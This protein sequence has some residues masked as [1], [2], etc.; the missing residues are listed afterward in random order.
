MLQTCRR[1]FSVA[2][3]FSALWSFALVANG[4][5]AP[6]LGH[7]G[8]IHALWP[9]P[10]LPIAISGLLL[11][12][13]LALLAVRLQH[14]PQ[15]LL[16]LSSGFMLIICM[17]VATLSQWVPPPLAPRISW[18]CFII[19]AYPA[20]VP[21]SP[22]R[23]LALS[24]VAASMD[25]LALF[26]TSLRGVAF[27]HSAF[28]YIFDFVPTY[29][30]A[31]VAVVPAKII[32]ALSH[33]VR[34][35][36]EFGSYRLEEVLGKGGMGE[37]YRGT[38]QMLA[39]PAAVKIIRAEVLGNSSTDG[40][41]VIV[42]R[43]RR[44]AEAAASLRSPHTISL[45]DFGAADDGTFF[46]VMELLD[47]LD[48]QSLV[49]R[50]GPLPPERVAYLLRQVC[51][52]LEEAHV[53]GL[54]HRDI[55]PSNIFTCRLGLQTDFVKVLDFGLVK[56]RGELERRDTMLTA[57]DA[58][59]GTPAY[60]A[61][62]MV[63]GGVPIDHRVDIYALGCVAYWL[64]TGQLVFE[65]PNAIQLMIAH[66]QTPPIPPSQR[67]ELDIPPDFEA[68]V[69]ACLAK[70]PE[71]RPATAAELG[72]RLAVAVPAP[73]WGEESAQRWWNRH[74]PESAR[75]AP[76]RCDVLLSRTLAEGWSGEPQSSETTL[77]G[78]A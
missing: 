60:I 40:A 19:L 63:R 1:V 3:V 76:T 18:L 13:L 11:S 66:F 52:S 7:V 23:T 72:R 59:A 56:G 39:R 78:K 75:A 36:R 31:L 41:R 8:I 46:L 29:M 49:E 27:E 47:G 51:E 58:T 42:E 45:Y 6:L 74:H 4:I 50:F 32:R 48:L 57:P 77:A 5:L 17:M 70:R 35:A 53:R 67:V 69:M 21:A 61:P 43:F 55:K 64:L 54:I 38:H 25:P 68:V 10:G 37:V 30:A 24:L 20:I 65:A 28:Y 22:E 14:R 34:R 33:Q 16:D 12:L 2:L 15:L 9:Y 71:D 26:F 44:E 62:E 73:G